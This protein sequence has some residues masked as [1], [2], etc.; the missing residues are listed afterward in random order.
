LVLLLEAAQLRCAE[1]EFS[2]L[3]GAVPVRLPP[4]VHPYYGIS[5][6]LKKEVIVP[7]PK[8]TLTPEQLYEKV[9]ATAMQKHVMV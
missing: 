5:S 7:E 9:R 4:G 8:I 2:P 1:T 3:R 6:R